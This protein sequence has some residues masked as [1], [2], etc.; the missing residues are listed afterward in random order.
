[1]Y[2]YL[3]RVFSLLPFK[4]HAAQREL[5]AVNRTASAS[6]LITTS[7]DASKALGFERAVVGT[8]FIDVPRRGSVL[9][10]RGAV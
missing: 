4:A 1:M 10:S 2:M 6:P 5:S 3:S 9:S 7:S 8:S